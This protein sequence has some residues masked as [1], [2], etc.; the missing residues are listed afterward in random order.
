MEFKLPA[1]SPCFC[2]THRQLQLF[3]PTASDPP[4]CISIHQFKYSTITNKRVKPKPMAT[5]HRPA[6]AGRSGQRCSA[7]GRCGAP[8]PAAGRLRLRSSALPPCPLKL[9]DG[10]SRLGGWTLERRCRRRAT[11]GDRSIHQPS[12]VVVERLN[13]QLRVFFGLVLMKNCGNCIVISSLMYMQYPCV[14]SNNIMSMLLG[15]I[16]MH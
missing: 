5:A 8:A 1:Y 2:K 7:K 10:G 15:K 16:I 11:M 13:K 6:A 3:R 14:Q 9:K 12:A 4:P